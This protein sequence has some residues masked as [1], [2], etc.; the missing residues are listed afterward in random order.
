MVKSDAVYKVGVLYWNNTSMSQDMTQV[1]AAKWKGKVGLIDATE[2]VRASTY[3][4][5]TDVDAAWDTRNCKNNNW[6]FNSDIWWTMSPHSYGSSCNV[7]SVYS[8]GTFYYD[9]ARYGF[10]VRP[11]VYLSPNVKIT[12]GTGAE[13]DPFLLE[14]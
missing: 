1:S 2:Y 4:S 12:G 6:M 5:C 10:G 13:T 7:W 11:A 3:S 8:D 9:Y 14:N